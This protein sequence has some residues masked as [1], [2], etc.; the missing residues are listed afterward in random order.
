MD[1][2]DPRPARGG[3]TGRSGAVRQWLLLTRRAAPWCGGTG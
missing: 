1:V 2:S 3:P